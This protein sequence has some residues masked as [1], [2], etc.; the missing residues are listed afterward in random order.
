MTS[1]HKLIVPAIVKTISSLSLL[2]DKLKWWIFLPVKGKKVSCSPTKSASASWCFVWNQLFVLIN[3][4]KLLSL[5]GY[6]SW[7]IISKRA[8]STIVVTCKA[9]QTAEFIMLELPITQTVLSN[10]FELSLL[11]PHGHFFF[12]FSFIGHLNIPF[13]LL[14]NDILEDS[15]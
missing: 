4:T 9:S 8:L 14:T 7:K 5:L 1:S 12:L 3:E 15:P 13:Y 6:W 2:L 11:L 10:A